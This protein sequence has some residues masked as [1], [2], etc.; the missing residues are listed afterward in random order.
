[1]TTGG[2]SAYSR[3]ISFVDGAIVSLHYPQ[4]SQQKI[5]ITEIKPGLMAFG[6]FQIGAGKAGRGEIDLVEAFTGQ[7]DA[8]FAIGTEAGVFM[9]PSVLFVQLNSGA[10]T[11]TPFQVM[12]NTPGYGPELPTDTGLYINLRFHAGNGPSAFLDVAAH[13][14]MK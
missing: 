9:G 10:A 11:G 8:D 6:P 2:T 1:M 4:G 13:D 14:R 12:W 7:I 5:L 3:E